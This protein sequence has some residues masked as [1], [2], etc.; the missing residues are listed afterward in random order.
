MRIVDHQIQFDPCDHELL[1]RLLNDEFAAFEY[2]QQTDLNEYARI[3]HE[4]GDTRSTQEL[5]KKKLMNDW[6]RWSPV[7][8][9]KYTNVMV[10]EYFD[11]HNFVIHAGINIVTSA[12][13]LQNPVNWVEEITKYFGTDEWVHYDQCIY[14]KD[15]MIQTI[16]TIMK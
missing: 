12:M 6:E 2:K 7:S 4:L 16:L 8:H 14:F 13:G 3:A 15:P 11:T 1:N 9:Y 10:F 5:K